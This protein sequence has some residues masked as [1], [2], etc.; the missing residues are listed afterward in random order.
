MNKKIYIQPSLKVIE[1]EITDILTGSIPPRVFRI[2]NDE[3]DE[4]EKHTH[5]VDTRDVWGK[6]W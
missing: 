6:Q 3:V 4:Y 5:D 1:L 2:M